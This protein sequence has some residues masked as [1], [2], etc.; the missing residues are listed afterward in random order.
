MKK[1]IVLLFACLIF[2]GCGSAETEEEKTARLVAETKAA[3]SDYDYDIK[4]DSVKLTKYN[5]KNEVLYILSEYESDGNRYK[6]DLS[7]FSCILGSSKVKFIIF[8]NGIEE[9]A[10]PT[11]NCSGVQAVYFPNTMKHIY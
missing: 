11:F 2:T 6:T 5:G 8:E 9:I 4:E 10:N 7:D 3:L 1:M